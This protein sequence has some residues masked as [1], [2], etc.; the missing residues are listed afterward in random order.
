LLGVRAVFGDDLPRSTEFRHAVVGALDSLQHT[1]SRNT[2][3][4]WI[5]GTA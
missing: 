1:G 5:G 3:A 2:A 4:A